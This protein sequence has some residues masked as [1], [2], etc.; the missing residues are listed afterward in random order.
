MVVW[1]IAMAE[2]LTFYTDFFFLLAINDGY[3][4]TTDLLYLISQF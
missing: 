1:N 4:H 3:D 2:L